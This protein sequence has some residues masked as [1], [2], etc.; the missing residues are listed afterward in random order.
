MPIA[1]EIY[2]HYKSTGWNDYTY[3]IIWLAKHSETGDI[4][5][6]YKPLYSI[7]DSRLWDATLVVRPLHMRE[8]EIIV[9]GNVLKRFT[10]IG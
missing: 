8:D 4:L 9:D 6:V 2:R 5:V 1:W 10:K 7:F 3:Q